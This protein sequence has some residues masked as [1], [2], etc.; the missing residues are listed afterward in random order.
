[1]RMLRNACLA[2]LCV[3]APSTAVY[4]VAD[5]SSLETTGAYEIPSLTAWGKIFSVL[6]LVA[7]GVAYIVWRRP[8]VQAQ[9]ILET[10]P[11]GVGQPVTLV[12]WSLYFRTLLAIEVLALCGIG[13]LRIVGRPLAAL[14]MLGVIASGAIVALVVHLL[15]LARGGRERD[16]S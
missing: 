2:G 9:A 14:D 10:S 15:W 13:T 1:M 16:K 5:A 11:L 8:I 4:L 6:L 7:L 3:L 12:D